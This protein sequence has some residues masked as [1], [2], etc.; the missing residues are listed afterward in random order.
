MP[1]RAGVGPKSDNDMCGFCPGLGQFLMSQ[2]KVRIASDNQRHP[3][4]MLAISMDPKQIYVSLQTPIYLVLY[5][6]C[7]QSRILWYS[8][9]PKD[10]E[11]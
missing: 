5:I 11:M 3:G 7:F 4:R 9:K 6:S 10:S 1:I 2:S 8:S